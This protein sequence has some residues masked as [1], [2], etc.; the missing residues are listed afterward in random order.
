MQ[1]EKNRTRRVNLIPGA[2]LNLRKL[3]R[4][5][6]VAEKGP[7]VDGRGGNVGVPKD[8]GNGTQ[9][10]ARPGQIRR[11]GMPLTRAGGHPGP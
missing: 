7:G 9:V 11:A 10:V 2:T 8:V 6:L 3:Q 5:G 1:C 4:P